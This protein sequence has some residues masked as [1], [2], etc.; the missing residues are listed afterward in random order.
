M[1]KS[2]RKHS[3]MI[4][5]M[6]E[7]EVFSDARKKLQADH[8]QTM[9]TP[10]NTDEPAEGGLPSHDLLSSAIEVC[11]CAAHIADILKNLMEIR[12]TI[13]PIYLEKFGAESVIRQAKEA[14]Y[15]MDTI[16]D[17]LNGCDAVSEEDA[18]WDATFEKARALFP[19][20]NS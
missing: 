6:R 1:K 18:I 12:P 3:D 10:L 9:K 8:D 19:L 2:K 4:A 17:Y 7:Q 15:W 14:H 5:T 20:D 16:G 11:K 13:L